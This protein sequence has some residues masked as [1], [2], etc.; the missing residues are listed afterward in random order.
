MFVTVGQTTEGEEKAVR[1]EKGARETVK[2]EDHF[3]MN[4]FITYMYS[5]CQF[6]SVTLTYS[7]Y[8]TLNVLV[9]T[10]ICKPL[11]GE[12]STK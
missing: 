5:I 9:V 7:F 3:A 11:V 12:M 10:L 2:L 6:D 4:V 8:S 1:K